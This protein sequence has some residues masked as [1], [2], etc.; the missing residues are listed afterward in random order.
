MRIQ[1][2]IKSLINQIHITQDEI[3][4]WKFK[5]KTREEFPF[6]GSRGSREKIYQLKCKFNENIH[7][8]FYILISIL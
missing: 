1:K 3:C 6:I 5:K 4:M 7:S 8:K 2:T